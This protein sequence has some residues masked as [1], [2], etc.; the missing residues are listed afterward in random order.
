MSSPGNSSGWLFVASLVSVLVL[1][2]CGAGFFI[3]YEYQ[4]EFE[5]PPPPFHQ[6][7]QNLTSFQYRQLE[8]L[9]KKHLVVIRE[10][11][12]TLEGASALTEKLF[13]EFYSGRPPD[14]IYTFT[15]ENQQHLNKI[16]LE[17]KFKVLTDSLVIM[18]YYDL[19]I[20]SPHYFIGVQSS[21]ERMEQWIEELRRLLKAWDS[22]IEQT[23]QKH[24]EEK[25]PEGRN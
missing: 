24:V 19:Q 6:S 21:Q 7:R 1:A 18:L 17:A 11:L 8:A 16:H 13:T 5:S 12:A 3:T 9:R 20:T 25:G 14:R 15:V 10:H 4:D 22:A 23:L 2:V